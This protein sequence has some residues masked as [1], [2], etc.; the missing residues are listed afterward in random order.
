VRRAVVFAGV[1]AVVAA[2]GCATVLSIP[3][4]TPSY[5]ASNPGHDYCEDFD[6]GDA[7]SRWTFAETTGGAT[8]SLEPSDRSAPNLLDLTCP[9][10]PL[11]SSGLAGF[12]REFDQSTFAGVHVEAD[13]R[14]VTDDGEPPKAKG[15]ILLVVDKSGGCIGI[16]L[17]TFPGGGSGLGAVIFPEATACSA[18]TGS[19]PGATSQPEGGTLASTPAPNQW[20][21]VVLVV[22]PDPSGNGAGT[23][24]FDIVGQPSSVAPVAIPAGTLVPNGIPLV[25]FAAEVNGPSDGLEVQY[26]NVT[27]DLKGS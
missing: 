18:L 13:V 14:I 12:T 20:F 9:S 10:Q 19:G 1:A 5:C 4:G 21:H 8:M 3:D 11:G 26:D 22:T 2:A 25:G 27:I 16:G 15:G 7:G 17:G 24:S 6:V 23:L